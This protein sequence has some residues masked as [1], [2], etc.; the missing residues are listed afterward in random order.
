M[1]FG[2]YPDVPL[3]LARERL[4]EARKLLATGID[5]MEQRKAEKTA[6]QVATENSFAR[7]A[8]RCVKGGAKPGHCSGVKV[9]QRK[10]VG[11]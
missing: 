2:R 5:P 9:G 3:G 11:V 10:V 1:T 4:A 6:E 8:A 7:V